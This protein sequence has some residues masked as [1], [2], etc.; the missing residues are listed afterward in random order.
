MSSAGPA[1][2]CSCLP[3]AAS[4]Q[5]PILL[6]CLV[7]SSLVWPSTN[8]TVAALRPRSFSHC[9]LTCNQSKST[10][11]SI[12][13][14]GNSTYFI[15]SPN[16][17]LSYLRDLHPAV[18]PSPLSYHIA[19]QHIQPQIPLS[20]FWL[21]YNSFGYRTGIWI[22]LLVTFILSRLLAPL[23]NYMYMFQ[24][25]V[26]CSHSLLQWSRYDRFSMLPF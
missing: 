26:S 17:S 19:K 10:V 9:Y 18:P 1:F 7:Q 3:Y 25:P 21:C 5:Y 16:S 12:R 4:V 13:H 14:S 8:C 20:F 22:R 11:P 2:S 15:S 6:Q 23:Q 24:R